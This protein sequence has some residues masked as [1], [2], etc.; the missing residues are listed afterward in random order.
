MNHF[1]DPEVRLD[2]S[3]SYVGKVVFGFSGSFINRTVNIIMRLH[4]YL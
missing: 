2:V 4:K 3:Y 1:R